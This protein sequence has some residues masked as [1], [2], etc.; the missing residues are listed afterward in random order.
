MQKD[1][2]F[3]PLELCFDVKFLFGIKYIQQFST[4]LAI[5]TENFQAVNGTPHLYS[6]SFPLRKEN[7]VTSLD[8]G[9]I[10][11]QTPTEDNG[12]GGT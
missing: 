11:E 12:K 7:P 8:S 2:Y 1:T 9:I 10:E 4:K 6:S 5:A 3:W